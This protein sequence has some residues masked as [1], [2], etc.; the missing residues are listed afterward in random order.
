MHL[1][2]LFYRELFYFECLFQFGD[3]SFKLITTKLF[4]GIESSP[5]KVSFPQVNFTS[6]GARFLH[7]SRLSMNSG[8]TPF[9]PPLVPIASVATISF[10]F[11]DAAPS[12]ATSAFPVMAEPSS[13]VKHTVCSSSEP[14]AIFTIIA[15]PVVLPVALPF[16][17]SAA[18]LSSAFTAEI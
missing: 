8:E 5:L 3:Y 16:D 12:L 6:S 18:F 17:V 14:F 4:A 15:L 11:P 1:F 2:P 10:A 13:F 7:T 9:V